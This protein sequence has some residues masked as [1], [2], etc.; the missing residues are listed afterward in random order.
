MSLPTE[1]MWFDSPPRATCGAHDRTAESVC[2]RCGSFQCELCVTPSERSLC[3]ACAMMVT[4]QTLPGLSRRAAWKLVLLPL[5]G[6]GCLLALASKGAPL[7]AL[8]AEQLTF[9]AAW[10]IPF[11]C[12]LGLLL[13]PL[14]PL[15][16]IG[17]LVSLTL[18]CVVLVPPVIADFNGQRVL[19]LVILAA[20]PLVAVRDAFAIDR[21][22]RQ[23][24]LLLSMANA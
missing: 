8:N 24:H 11:G 16:F 3:H 22:H 5:V 14:A 18:V 13:R 4:T 6:I 19:D 7:R 20:A 1:E 23:R 21:T 9:L 15:A 10:L 17:S 12:G 2:S